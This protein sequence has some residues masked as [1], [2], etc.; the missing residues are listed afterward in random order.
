[1]KNSISHV[2]S[3]V[4]MT[5]LVV[6]TVLLIFQKELRGRYI[7]KTLEDINYYE[8]A[9]ENIITGVEDYIVNDEVREMYVDYITID[10]VKSDINKILGNIY[11][12]EDTKFS[13]YNDFYK[14]IN[15]YNDDP[16]IDDKYASGIN[17]IYVKNIFP[18][19]EFNFIHKLHIANVNVL[20]VA[21]LLLVIALFVFL[22]L[23]LINKNFKYHIIGIMGYGTILLLPKIIIKV[24]KIFDSFLY[25]NP[26]YTK[27]LL[28][29]MNNITNSLLIIG[30][31]VIL[32]TIIYKILIRKRK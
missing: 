13:R 20:F 7:R 24:F 15:S 27:F 5:L 21:L 12:D 28:A 18:I 4:L 29:I 3:F 19:Y 9:Y 31:L 32:L 30:L 22:A 17:N 8:L 26:Y 10:L 14:I 23:F 16:N 11:Q 1:M 6:V 25:T 2:L